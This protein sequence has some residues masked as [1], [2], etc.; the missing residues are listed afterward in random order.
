MAKGK[1]R[2]IR[3]SIAFDTSGEAAQLAGATRSLGWPRR[4]QLYCGPRG[5]QHDGQVAEPHV[6]LR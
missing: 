4:S 1:L 2:A 5:L 3:L 6:K